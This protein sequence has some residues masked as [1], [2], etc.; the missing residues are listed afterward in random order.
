MT[1]EADEI[2]RRR[3]ETQSGGG[4]GERGNPAGILPVRG[5]LVY[6]CM[7]AFV[8]TQDVYIPLRSTGITS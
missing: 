1:Y 2:P 4:A 7:H 3:S 5:A 8:H 6:V